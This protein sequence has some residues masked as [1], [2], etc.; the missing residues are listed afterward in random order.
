MIWLLHVRFNSKHWKNPMGQPV[1]CWVRSKELTDQQIGRPAWRPEFW[2]CCLIQLSSE[3]WNFDPAVQLPEVLLVVLLT[4]LKLSFTRMQVFSRDR[5][6]T[7]CLSYIFWRQCSSDLLIPKKNVT[8]DGARIVP[9][10]AVLFL[11]NLGRSRLW[12]ASWS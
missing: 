10:N 7:C 5:T 2:T 6:N 3:D 9:R 8:T 11:N 12:T 4:H 1:T